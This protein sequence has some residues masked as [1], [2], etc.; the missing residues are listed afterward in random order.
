MK[1]VQRHVAFAVCNYS[2]LLLTNLDEI[3]VFNVSLSGVLV[4]RAR[5]SSEE[6]HC[7]TPLAQ[8]HVVVDA[9][10]YLLYQ[11]GRYMPL[12][13]GQHFLQTADPLLHCPI[14]AGTVGGGVMILYMMGITEFLERCSETR[15]AVMY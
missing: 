7:H 15:S 1:G 6:A 13:L 4:L 11:L 5:G 10:S 3:E 14:A 9:K 12:C 2:L 8:C